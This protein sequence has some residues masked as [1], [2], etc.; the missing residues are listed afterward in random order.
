MFAAGGLIY[1]D[2]GMMSEIG[3]ARRGSLLDVFYGVY[4]RDAEAV[5]AA[6]IDLG[7]IV[8][9]ADAVSLRRAISFSLDNLLRKVMVMSSIFEGMMSSGCSCMLLH[10]RYWHM[11]L[12]GVSII[13][14][15]LPARLCSH[16]QSS[17]TTQRC[18]FRIC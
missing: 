11:Q 6:L 7:I 5:I 15:L 3:T 18:L 13:L 10:V 2:F 16:K 8:P 4:R 12:A 1:Y 9:T 17:H 14:H